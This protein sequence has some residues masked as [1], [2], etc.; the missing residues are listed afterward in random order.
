LPI[1]AHTPG[2]LV[3]SHSTFNVVRRLVQQGLHVGREC[4]LGLEDMKEQR[5]RLARAQR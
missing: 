5:R 3:S 1:V 2:A 4:A